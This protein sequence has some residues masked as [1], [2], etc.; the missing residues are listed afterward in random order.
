MNIYK[1]I[2]LRLESLFPGVILE[3]FP[4][5][6]HIRTDNWQIPPDAMRAFRE[7]GLAIDSIYTEAGGTIT[8]VIDKT[9]N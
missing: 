8:L 5:N 4:D 7:M 1:N 2:V 9:I 3:P 6:L